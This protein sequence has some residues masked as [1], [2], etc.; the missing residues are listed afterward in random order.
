MIHLYLNKVYLKANTT[1]DRFPHIRKLR[2][3]YPQL[4]YQYTIST[5]RI[6]YIIVTT[7][8]MVK[9]IKAS[10]KCITFTTGDNGDDWY[11]TATFMHMVS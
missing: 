10:Y 9:I 1:F 11:F 3:I 5:V 4:E 8:L 2:E 7:E 6:L